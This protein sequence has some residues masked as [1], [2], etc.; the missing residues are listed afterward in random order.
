MFLAAKEGTDVYWLIS[1]GD[2]VAAALAAG[3]TNKYWF[4]DQNTQS[5]NGTV[6]LKLVTV[7]PSAMVSVERVQIIADGNVVGSADSF[8]A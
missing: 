3:S 8:P 4:I 2:E 5:F 7:K 1:S 6:I